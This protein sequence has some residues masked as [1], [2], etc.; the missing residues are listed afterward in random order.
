MRGFVRIF[1]SDVRCGFPA[2]SGRVALYAFVCV[3]ALLISWVKVYYR[4]PEAVPGMTLGESVLCIWYGMM[5]YDP[6]EGRVFE[7]PMAWLCLVATA[8]FAVADYSS[9]EMGGMGASLVLACGNRWAWWLSKCLW[10]T[11]TIVGLVVVSVVVAALPIFA[12]GGSM[13]LSVRPGV[14]AALEA[15]NNFALTD[16]YRLISEGGAA[17]AATAAAS[18]DVSAALLGLLTCLVGVVLVQNAIALLYHP[19]M[20]M[21]LTLSVLFLSAYFFESWLPGE[22]M[23]LART[24][25]LLN[26]GIWFGFDPLRGVLLGTAISAVGVLVG[27]AAFARKDIM[28]RKEESR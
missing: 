27:G 26:T 22:Y 18:I 7:F 19:V 28:G 24:G 8:S 23:L 13:V 1:L 4:F 9:R 17:T 20:G 11:V 25:E 21:A 12:F 10:V 6:E 3:T 15:G 2:I 16:A 5:P 14:A